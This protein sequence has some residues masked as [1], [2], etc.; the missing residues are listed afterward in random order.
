MGA[1]RAASTEHALHYVLERVSS[2][3]SEGKIF[4]VLLLDIS[5]AFDKVSRPRLLHNLR[6]KGIDDRI[7]CWI[8]SFL[9]RRTTILKTNEHTPT[10]IDISVGIP[11]G[12]PLSPILF[13][14]YIVPLLEDLQRKKIEAC[15]F[16]DDTALIVQSNSA[17]RNREMLSN[18]HEE[19]CM[20]WASTHS[21][22]FAPKNTS[23]VILTGKDSLQRTP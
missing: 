1:R 5:G 6:K 19:V 23:C 13:L 17:R 20:P 16:V 11:Q 7:V 9:S 10:K 18:I 12:S 22:K 21:A 14:F 8:E 3:W 15:G 2:A 4:T